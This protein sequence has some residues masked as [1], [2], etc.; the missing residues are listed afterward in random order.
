MRLMFTRLLVQKA[1]HLWKKVEVATDSYHMGGEG[2][3]LGKNRWTIVGL[4]WMC[5][6]YAAGY[7]RHH[8]LALET[9]LPVA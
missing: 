2:H 9:T 5:S 7:V 1:S 4:N 8:D 3:E 6:T